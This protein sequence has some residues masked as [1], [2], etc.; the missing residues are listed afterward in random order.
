MHIYIYS[1]YKHSFPLWFIIGY[2]L[3]FSVLYS[4]TLLFILCR[5]LHLLTPTSHPVLP[6]TLSSLATTCLFLMYMILS[7]KSFGLNSWL[8]TTDLGGSEVEMKFSPISDLIKTSSPRNKD[9][10]EQ[11]EGNQ[12]RRRKCVDTVGPWGAHPFALP[13]MA[14]PGSGMGGEIS[15]WLWDL[16]LVGEGIPRHCLGRQQENVVECC[17]WAEK[18]L[19][20][21][22]ECPRLSKARE[23]QN[24]PKRRVEVAESKPV[25]KGPWGREVMSQ[26]APVCA[27]DGTCFNIHQHEQW[28]KWNTTE[29]EFPCWVYN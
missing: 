19:Y 18:A 17:S 4:R 7:F 10:P 28:P 27:D 9:L 15:D 6:P 22:A 2:W 26:Q 12:R 13:P 11:A 24:E 1:F 20:R 16:D 14:K 23:L 21:W 3:W 29:T 8:W 25:L 5:S